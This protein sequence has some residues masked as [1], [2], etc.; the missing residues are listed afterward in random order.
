VQATVIRL[1]AVLVLA[2]LPLPW[3]SH[4]LWF[5]LAMVVLA[6]NALLL[7]RAG[8]AAGVLGCAMLLLTTLLLRRGGDGDAWGAYVALAAEL[9]LVVVGVLSAIAERRGRTRAEG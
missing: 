5:T 7:A 2:S 9:G 3:P 8:I 6:L 4:E 1:L